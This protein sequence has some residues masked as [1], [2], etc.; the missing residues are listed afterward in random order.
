MPCDIEEYNEYIDNKPHYVLRLYGYLVNGQK[1]VVTISGI[2]VSLIFVFLLT[3]IM[4]YS[5]LK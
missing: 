3:R 2:K 4:K 5:K 1:A